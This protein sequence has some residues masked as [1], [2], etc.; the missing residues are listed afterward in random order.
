MRN[1]MAHP[2]TLLSCLHQLQRCDFFGLEQLYR[3]HSGQLPEGLLLLL[4]SHSAAGGVIE[5]VLV[6]KLVDWRGVNCWTI[7]A[8]TAQNT[9][10]S[11]G[12]CFAVV[13]HTNVAVS[14]GDPVPLVYI[15]RGP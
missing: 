10:G 15:A 7:S 1:A 14:S 12:S 3:C 2:P 5:Q 9:V 8:V 6:I 11:V 4:L 13:S